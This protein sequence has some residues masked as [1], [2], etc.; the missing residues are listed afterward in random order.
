M[1]ISQSIQLSFLL[2]LVSLLMSLIS[3]CATEGSASLQQISLS[4]RIWD[5]QA[6]KTIEKHQFIQKLM[7]ADFILLGETHD[8]PEH[9]NIEVEVLQ[10]LLRKENPPA[11]V[12]EMLDLEDQPGIDRFLETKS[13]DTA[14]FNRQTGFSEKGWDWPLY[15]PLLAI[16]LD[17]HLK[18]V[19]GNLSRK[20]L[21]AVIKNGI[22]A[23]PQ[24]VRLRLDQSHKIKPA[25]QQQLMQDI[26]DSHCGKLPEAMVPGMTEA[27]IARDVMLAEQTAEAGKPALLIAGSGHVR[28]DRS[29]SFYLSQ[30]VPDAKIISVGL[31]GVD[32]KTKPAYLAEQKNLFDY[33]WYTDSVE[34]EDP[35]AGFNLGR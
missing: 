14:E 32:T 6:G 21:M 5:S 15:R 27:Q 16:A 19:A 20:Q 2:V 11:L 33:L 34:R 10:A 22:S 17:H 12:L 13:T 9:H 26:R 18:I 30:I 35:C 28:R 24:T 3:G 25:Q 23:A 1:K 8:N 31:L 4:G 7:Q 29:A